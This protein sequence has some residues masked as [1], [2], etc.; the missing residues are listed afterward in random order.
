MSLLSYTQSDT[1]VFFQ[2]AIAA[3]HGADFLGIV[4]GMFLVTIKKKQIV[5]SKQKVYSDNPR[6]EDCLIQGAVS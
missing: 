1:N 3:A 6:T 5:I 4:Y 2:Q